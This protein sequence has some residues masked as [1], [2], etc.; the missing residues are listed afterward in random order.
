MWLKKKIFIGSERQ[1]MRNNSQLVLCNYSISKYI[2]MFVSGM[3][4]QILKCDRFFFHRTR[5]GELDECRSRY[6][7]QLCF[8]NYFFITATIIS[9]RTHSYVSVTQKERKK[10]THRRGQH[11]DGNHIEPVNEA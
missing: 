8:M 3:K 1:V 10:T 9:L 7:R 6:C 11:E 4:Y 5:C 2:F